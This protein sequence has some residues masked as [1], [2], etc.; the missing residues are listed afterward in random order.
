M[1]KQLEK[2][3]GENKQKLSEFEVICDTLQREL[4]ESRVEYEKQSMQMKKLKEKNSK[5]KHKNEELNKKTTT[6]ERRSDEETNKLREQLISAQCENK[7][8][9]DLVEELQHQIVET[10]TNMN[11]M[12]CDKNADIE[13]KNQTHRSKMRDL[14]EKYEKNVSEKN[15]QITELEKLFDEEQDHHRQHFQKLME[16][17]NEY[18]QTQTRIQ[19]MYEVQLNLLKKRFENAI[20]NEQERVSLINDTQSVHTQST[21]SLRKLGKSQHATSSRRSLLGK[22]QTVSRIAV[23]DYSS[24]LYDL[25]QRDSALKSLKNELKSVKLALKKKEKENQKLSKLNQSNNNRNHHRNDKDDKMSVLIKSK[26][27]EHDSNSLFEIRASAVWSARLAH[28]NIQ[29]VE[30]KKKLEFEQELTIQ[31]D[32]DIENYK[33]D[34][35]QL[36]IQIESICKKLDHQINIKSKKRLSFETERQNWKFKEREFEQQQEKLLEDI[37]GYKKTIKRLREDLNRKEV[38]MRQFKEDKEKAINKMETLKMKSKSMSFY[39]S[40]QYK[41]LN[42]DIESAR[43]QLHLKENLLIDFKK[44]YQKLQNNFDKMQTNN[45]E[46]QSKHRALNSEISRKE[47]LI[48][49]LKHKLQDIER[50]NISNKTNSELISKLKQKCKQLKANENRKDELWRSNKERL[51]IV[52]KELNDLKQNTSQKQFKLQSKLSKIQNEEESVTKKYSQLQNESIQ[53]KAI[54]DTLYGK[55]STTNDELISTLN[56]LQKNYH[57]ISKYNDD[58]N[59]FNNDQADDTLKAAK[60]LDDFSVNELQEIMHC[61]ERKQILKPSSSKSSAPKTII[62]DKYE[63]KKS[64]IQL[65]EKVINERIR[66]EMMVRKLRIHEKAA[67]DL[68]NDQF[69]RIKMKHQQ[70]I[71]E[72]QSMLNKFRKHK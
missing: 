41:Q 17:F 15:H 48:N 70:H 61:K 44:K 51:E 11:K 38:I 59:K 66:L 43:N 45:H 37:I 40:K 39:D 4:D 63:E 26:T 34:N 49:E 57:K 72:Y 16:E 5:L 24:L 46:L 50:E 23:S 3:N 20:I 67:N 25:S 56:D 29:I 19:K 55:L 28:C 12:K 58:N 60:I 68:Q 69:E 47:V 65:F 52:T 1:D 54:M 22:Q 42:K 7:K 62:W 35:K 31:K 32:E 71:N 14:N 10:E 9:R 30:L 8:I 13:M 33:F 36:K 6:F 27:N 53:L 21:V 2:S 64:I 18:K